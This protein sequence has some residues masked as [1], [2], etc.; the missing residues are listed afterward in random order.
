MYVLKTDKEEKEDD[1]HVFHLE[2][3]RNRTKGLTKKQMIK[4]NAEKSLQ[5]TESTYYYKFKDDLL[6][7]LDSELPSNN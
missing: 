2:T 4:A 1:C 7:E 6:A 5:S 3:I